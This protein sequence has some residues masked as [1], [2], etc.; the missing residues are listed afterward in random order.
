MQSHQRILIGAL[1]WL[2]Q[3]TLILFRFI[4]LSQARSEQ[5]PG[6]GVYARFLRLSTSG[7]EPIIPHTRLFQSTHILFRFILL[8]QARIFQGKGSMAGSW[9]YQHPDQ[10]QSPICHHHTW[11]EGGTYGSQGLI[12]YNQGD[13]QHHQGPLTSQRIIKIQ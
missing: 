11:S 10:S 12:T 9:G 7:S 13:P 3:S 4:L 5:H 8:S 1:I 2:F 6:K